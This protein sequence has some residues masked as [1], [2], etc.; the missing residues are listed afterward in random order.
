MILFAITYTSTRFLIDY[1]IITK[2]TTFSVVAVALQ[3]YRI[4][5]SFSKRNAFS[6]T[7]SA[8]THNVRAAWR[9]GGFHYRSCGRQTFNFALPFPR[10]YC[11]RCAKPPV[12]C[13]HPCPSVQDN[14]GY[15]LL[16]HTKQRISHFN[17]S[18]SGFAL[19]RQTLSVWAVR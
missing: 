6:T 10:A 17:C 13:W 12:R 14:R 16:N 1:K 11:R 8:L 5:L 19:I 15:K 9:S 2:N 18:L 7:L 3:R 4:A